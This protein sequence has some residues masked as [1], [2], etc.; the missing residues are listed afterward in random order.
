[1]K[2]LPCKEEIP[3]SN[4]IKFSLMKIASFKN[5]MQTQFQDVKNEIDNVRKEMQSQVHEQVCNISLF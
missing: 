5:S 4:L 3:Y 1:M 2:K